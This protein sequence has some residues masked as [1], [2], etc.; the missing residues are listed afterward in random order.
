[1][2]TALAVALAVVLTTALVASVSAL[3]RHVDPGTVGAQPPDPSSL[4]GAYLL[5]AQSLGNEEYSDARRL[6]SLLLNSTAPGDLA[7]VLRR[8]HELVVQESDLLNSSR[9][10]LNLARDAALRGDLEGARALLGEALKALVQA[11]VTRYNLEY[12]ARA[13]E[14][15]LGA[16][17]LQVVATVAGLIGKHA[18][19]ADTLNETFIAG[20]AETKLT[21]EAPSEAW[22]GSY[23]ELR[24]LLTAGGEP[25]PAR[26]VS[27][28]LDGSVSAT[29]VTNER[30]EY[31]LSV[32]IPLVYRDYVTVAAVYTPEGSDA[33]VYAPSSSEPARI[34]LLYVVPY[35]NATAVPREAL[36]GDTIHVAIRSNVSNLYVKVSAFGADS[37]VKLRGFEATVDVAVPEDAAE[38]FYRVYVASEPNGT[39]GPASTS[40]LVAVRK[41]PIRVA[42][43]R[44]PGVIVAPLQAELVVCVET[45][46]EALPPYRVEARA[47]GLVAEA[48]GSGKCTSTS[49]TPSPLTPT[50]PLNIT[51]TVVPLDTRFKGYSTTSGTLVVN[52]YAILAATALIV[53]TVASIAKHFPLPR[54][55]AE[56]PKPTAASQPPPSVSEDTEYSAKLQPRDPVLLE[57]I[58]AVRSIEKATGV[59][60][61]P[62]HT[63]REYLDS[64]RGALGEAVKPFSQLSMLA[65]LR[66]YANAEVDPGVAKALREA[67][68]KL[69]GGAK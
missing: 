35:L 36:P 57:Y 55:G 20:L 58:L 68:E 13:I 27:I 11:N 38:G 8:F 48:E 29:A 51:V 21:L 67:V 12:A 22:I 56:P 34:K 32:S 33:G 26:R 47:P 61:K 40:T 62:S 66:L 42:D 60:L 25:L 19:E 1:M 39:V 2:K 4:T 54:R 17:A 43:V 9:S 52:M 65:E 3:P 15:R 53:A 28:V 44:V 24:G 50:G 7:F 14:Q 49:I 45:Q 37:Q 69:L 30:G 31:S 18:R 5:L 63:V 46:G 59:R 16:K 23:V 64:V 10:L 6:A 41:I